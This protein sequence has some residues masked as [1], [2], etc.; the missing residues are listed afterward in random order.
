MPNTDPILPGDIVWY[1]LSLDVDELYRG[2]FHV[3]EVVCEVVRVTGKRVV[4][5]PYFDGFKGAPGRVRSVS[6]DKVR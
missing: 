1:R 4:I 5:R 2:V 6:R 3:R